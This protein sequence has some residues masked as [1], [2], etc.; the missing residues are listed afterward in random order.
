MLSRV[1]ILKCGAAEEVYKPI[2]QVTVR[3][4][5]IAT[6]FTLLLPSSGTNSRIYKLWRWQNMALKQQFTS[7]IYKRE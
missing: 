6:W 2:R 7:I 4:K 5:D 3:F 1:S